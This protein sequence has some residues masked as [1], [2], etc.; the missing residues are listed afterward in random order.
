MQIK[1]EVTTSADMSSLRGVRCNYINEM[2]VLRDD[3]SLV[4]LLCNRDLKLAR[5]DFHIEGAQEV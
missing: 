5:D 2:R 4:C 1:H 3:Q